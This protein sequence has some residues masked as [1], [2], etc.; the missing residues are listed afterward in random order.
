MKLRF[1]S[2]IAAALLLT[3]P[4]T[5][6]AQ[7]ASPVGLVA[8]AP[9]DSTVQIRPQLHQTHRLKYGA[10]GALIGVAVGAGVGAVLTSDCEHK[11]PGDFCVWYFTTMPAGLVIGTIVG[12]VLGGSGGERPPSSSDALDLGRPDARPAPLRVA[13]TVTF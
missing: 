4:S 9:S 5:A 2:A 10:I 13:V 12:V 8:A 6:S 7:E 11:N 1:P 3:L